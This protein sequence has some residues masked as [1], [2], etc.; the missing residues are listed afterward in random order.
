MLR[1]RKG[2]KTKDFK[3]EIRNTEAKN[4]DRRKQIQEQKLMA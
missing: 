4:I 2:H 3:Y 1:A